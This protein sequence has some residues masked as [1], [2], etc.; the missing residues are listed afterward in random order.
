MSLSEV[1]LVV[2]D[3][4][5]HLLKYNLYIVFVE[6]MLQS[7]AILQFNPAR[8]KN[9]KILQPNAQFMMS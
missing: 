6:A 1:I 3:T 2:P 9:R 8:L 7:P 4:I 5:K